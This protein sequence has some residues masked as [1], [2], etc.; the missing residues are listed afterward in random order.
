MAPSRS[1]VVLNSLVNQ[2]PRALWKR[3]GI[4]L[5][6]ILAFL[7]ASHTIES[8]ALKD[9]KQHAATINLSGKQRVLS[10]Q[11]VLFSQA[12]IS[13][14]E[15]GALEALSN[16]IDAFER[17]HA[18]LMNDAAREQSL[19][20][21]YLSRTPSTDEIVRDFISIARDIP[22]TPYPTATLA[23]L[24]SKGAGIVLERLDEAVLAFEERVK[25]QARWAH[26]LQVITVL[27]AA[28]V[29]LLE[30]LFIFLPA[31]RLV[32]RTFLQLRT[33][34]ETDPLTLL[35]NRTGFDK[36]L[37]AAMIG[38]E[39]T[40][41]SVTL[42][43][44]DLDDFK[45]INDRYGHQTGDAVLKIVGR[46]ISRLP[47]LISA[48][49]VG[50]DE[51]AILVDNALWNIPE[52]VDAIKTDIRECMDFVYQAVEYEGLV[53]HVSGSVGL[54]R[55]PQ[56]AAD[57]TNLR[58][59]ASVSLIDA[60]G[61]GRAGLSIYDSRLDNIVRQRRIIQSAL[62]SG[63]YKS[64]LN[65]HFQPMVEVEDQNI[66]SVEV[67]ARWHHAELGNLN[68]ELF[69]SIARECGM[70]DEVESRLRSLA[71]EQISPSLKAGLIGSVSINI[72]PVDLAIQG[73]AAT[74][75]AQIA[76]Y[77]VST[78]QV[79]IEITETER[80]TSRVTV[81]NNLEMFDRAGVRIALDDY[82][83]GYSNIQRLAELPIKRVKID[84]SIVQE[85]AM[86]PKYAG[87]FRSSVQL[88]K[89]LGAEV[90]AEGVETAGQLEIIQRMGCKLVQ[91]YY[92][93]K[94]MPAEEFLSHLNERLS[95][96]A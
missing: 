55:F 26:Q 91:G 69:L 12:Y 53:I 72:S 54:S 80:L 39:G 89:A 74:L 19:G 29:V 95:S 62:L 78:A 23:E 82:G 2:D 94:P 7:A 16:S 14:D 42:V 18:D 48:A 13:N 46:R 96:V 64:D 65:V 27:L 79:W 30:A 90:V 83:V 71:L 24:Q 63:E 11:I 61:S 8:R 21:L 1:F 58:R 25:R 33:S 70:G 41:R 67:L 34:V 32:Q 73:F 6:I 10:Q 17:S 66:L 4:A 59:N 76:R 9:A 3:Y 35:R 40:A 56:D 15:P 85:T 75:L 57:L 37:V 87:V 52:A 31:H 86:D 93:F 28:I 44:L 5:F 36:D 38:D 68:P 43:L 60:K 92:F 22:N 47:N 50:G 51:F 81:S 84:K 20:Q 88:A 49:R 77:D 45:G